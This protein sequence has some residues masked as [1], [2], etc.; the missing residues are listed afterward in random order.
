MYGSKGQMVSPWNQWLSSDPTGASS[1]ADVIVPA[2]PH[3]SPTPP[4]ILVDVPSLKGW[5]TTCS[6]GD[7]IPS[8][9]KGVMHPKLKAEIEAPECPN[10]RWKKCQWPMLTRQA[11]WRGPGTGWQKSGLPPIL[12][13]MFRYTTLTQNRTTGPS[14]KRLKMPSPGAGK[15]TK[16]LPISWQVIPG[17]SKTCHLGN[18]ALPILAINNTDC[19]LT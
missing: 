7:T 12:F 18:K 4:G 14:I 9:A 11:F 5:L 16:D 10:K 3:P 8:K 13:R 17:V 2:S 19:T 15:L 6:R 1:P